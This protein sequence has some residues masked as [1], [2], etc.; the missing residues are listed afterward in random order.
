M[1]RECREK[2]IK[3]LLILCGANTNYDV[4]KT[5]DSFIEFIADSY[6]DKFIEYVLTN[7]DKYKKPII[8]IT[9]SATIFKKK[10]YL[11]MIKRNEMK[12][13]SSRDTKA[14]LFEFFKGKRIANNICGLYKPHVIVSLSEKGRFINEYVNEELNSK[15][16]NEFIIWCYENQKNIGVI[17]IIIEE[18]HSIDKLPSQHKVQLETNIDSP[19]VKELTNRLTSKVRV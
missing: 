3:H 5:V 8:N 16:E 9:T 19:E 17:N 15:K 12:L 14:F 13:K 4:I 6:L 1:R 7:W 11:M 10:M 2:K 18:H